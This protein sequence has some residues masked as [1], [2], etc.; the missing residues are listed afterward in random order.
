MSQ[1]LQFDKTLGKF[2]IVSTQIEEALSQIHYD[3]FDLS[4]EVHEQA[5]LSKRMND[6]YHGYMSFL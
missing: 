4:E 2:H 6:I 3:R 5:L 1:A